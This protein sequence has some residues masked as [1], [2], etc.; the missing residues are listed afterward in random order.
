MAKAC[1]ITPKLAGFAI[2]DEISNLYVP[3]RETDAAA[4]AQRYVI[5]LATAPLRLVNEFVPDVASHIHVQIVIL[6]RITVKTGSACGDVRSV[7]AYGGKRR[8]SADRNQA[9]ISGSARFNGR[10]GP[11]QFL[12]GCRL[13][14]GEIQKATMV[15]ASGQAEM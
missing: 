5:A 3:G 10:L 4:T 11:P 8:L 9:L 7:D 6:Q 2:C 12:R 14:H 1:R 13:A 15:T